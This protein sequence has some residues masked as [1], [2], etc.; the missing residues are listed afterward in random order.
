MLYFRTLCFN[1]ALIWIACFISDVT[2][3]FVV[4][5]GSSKSPLF[6]LPA[7]TGK[8][9]GFDCV[10]KSTIGLWSSTARNVIRV[11]HFGL[12]P[13]SAASCH[14]CCWPAICLMSSGW[15]QEIQMLQQN[16][17]GQLLMTN[18]EITFHE[19]Y[20]MF[21]V[22]YKYPFKSKEIAKKSYKEEHLMIF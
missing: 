14:H 22:I 6:N 9:P 8:L 21:W 17:L 13:P 18:W 11:F 4:S 1:S 15:I 19:Y 3:I 2:R 20:F 10:G 16:L 5:D 12:M 7:V